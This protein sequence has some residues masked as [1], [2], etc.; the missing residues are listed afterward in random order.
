M[1]SAISACVLYPNSFVHILS[2]HQII[3]WRV[4]SVGAQNKLAINCYLVDEVLLL[5]CTSYANLIISFLSSC[6]QPPSVYASQVSSSDESFGAEL[7]SGR[8]P[9]PPYPPPRTVGDSVLAMTEE[10]DATLEEAVM[11]CVARVVLPT[12]ANIN[13]EEADV[14]TE[15][16]LAI[17]VLSALLAVP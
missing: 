3:A 9:Y 10:L 17:R 5:Y 13:D 2:L 14:T 6:Y 11:I 15:E 12:T 4:H 1:P 7:A 8:W 16:A